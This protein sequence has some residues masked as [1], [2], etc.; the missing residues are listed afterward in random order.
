MKI[1]EIVCKRATK[2]ILSGRLSK[3][4]DRND[5]K[6]YKAGDEE[7]KQRVAANNRLETYAFQQTAEDGKSKFFEEDKRTVVAKCSEEQ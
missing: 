5:G 3:G 4:E 6:K 2:C 7:Q 1:G